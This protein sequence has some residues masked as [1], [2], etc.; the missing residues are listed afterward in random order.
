[1]LRENLK[2]LITTGQTSVSPKHSKRFAKFLDI[3]AIPF[4]MVEFSNKVFF[5]S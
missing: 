1:M 3:N 5:Y 4:D 2:Q